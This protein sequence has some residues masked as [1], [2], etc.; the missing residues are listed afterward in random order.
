MVALL[1]HLVAGI[2]HRRIDNSDRFLWNPAAE[3][4]LGG[5]CHGARYVVATGSDPQAGAL[6]AYV[7]D[8][9]GA[10]RGD[11]DFADDGQSDAKAPLLLLSFGH[12]APLRLRNENQLS[13]KMVKW[14]KGIEFLDT[15]EYL[16]GG[17]TA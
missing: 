5:L 6:R 3:D 1:A 7:G 11:G 2:R 15:F 8:V 13:F 16:G 17:R 12:G 10:A 14:I 4:A 9:C